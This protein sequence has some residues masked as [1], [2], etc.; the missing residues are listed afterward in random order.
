MT[1]IPDTHLN[2]LTEGQV[3]I[4]TTLGPDGEPQTTALWFLYEEGKV[5]MSI[6]EARQKL[7]NLRRDP[8]ASAFFIDLSNP[9]RT[10]ELRGNV[11]IEADPDYAFADR[12]GAKYNS[13]LRQMD[14]AGESRSMVTLVIDT[15]HTFG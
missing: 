10:L 3:V 14:K 12:V 9:Y 11:E 8:R 13:N 2:L 6:N 4:L 5:R 7:R 1:G 15:V